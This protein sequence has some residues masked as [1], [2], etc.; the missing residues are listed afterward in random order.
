[1]PVVASFSILGDLVLQVGGDR[2]Q[3]TQLVGPD[4]DAHVYHPSPRDVRRV[5]E[6]KLV[7]A[8]GL[9]FEGWM[10]RLVESSGFRG[11]LVIASEGIELQ[12]WEG[13]EKSHLHDGHEHEAPPPSAPDPHAWLS[14]ENV[15]H[16]VAN[17]AAALA[18]ADSAHALTY[19]QNARRYDAE[20]TA[21]DKEI[22]EMFATIPM[23]RRTL[24]T[25]H[26]AF[27]YFANRYQ[28]IMQAPQGVNTKQKPSAAG[29]ARIIRQIRLEGVTALFMENIT[30]P[31]QIRQ[32][33]RETDATIGGT[34]YSDALAPSGA[35]SD[36]IG[37]M[38][39]NAHT[40][41]KALQN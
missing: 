7:V 9:G 24:V 12:D 31:R 29:V 10:G 4:G 25:S 38:R 2:I 15:R 3:L 20:L 19:Q 17:I 13:A 16:Y 18:L 5:A 41:F 21:L 22:Q 28:I 14:V 6:A 27:G 33:A 35:A 30:D 36:Y 39:H 8:N 23:A 11:Q 40:I 37:L 32:I 34:L 26:D 1:L